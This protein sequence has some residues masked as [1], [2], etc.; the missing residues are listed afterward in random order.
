MKNERNFNGRLR[1]SLKDEPHNTLYTTRPAVEGIFA[2]PKYY[3]EIQGVG[4]D[5]LNQLRH[6]KPEKT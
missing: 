6:K 1:I 4:L 5:H 3:S 2:S